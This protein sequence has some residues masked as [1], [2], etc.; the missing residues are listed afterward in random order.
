VQADG[1]SAGSAPPEDSSAGPRPGLATPAG[2]AGRSAFF[3][4]RAG[5]AA[6]GSVTDRTP[7]SATYKSRTTRGATATSRA[8]G[9]P[10][11]TVL[12]RYRQRATLV[13]VDGTRGSKQRAAAHVTPRRRVGRAAAD[14][15]RGQLPGMASSC[16]QRRGACDGRSPGRPSRSAE[17][18]CAKRRAMRASLRVVVS[19]AEADRTRTYDDLLDLPTATHL[20]TLV[21]VWCKRV[22]ISALT[23][24]FVRRTRSRFPGSVSRS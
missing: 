14:E 17:A 18:G 6:A 9:E 4:S 3:D 19:S 20:V 7:C 2:P 13:V 15:I 8:L 1:A 23:W 22:D 24:P 11:S 21:R 12:P 10:L 16:P 5:R